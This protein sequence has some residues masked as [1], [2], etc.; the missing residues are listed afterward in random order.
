MI[1]SE[2]SEAILLD[3]PNS[4]YYPSYW[5]VRFNPSDMTYTTEEVDQVDFVAQENMYIVGNGFV[6]YPDLNWNPEEAILMDNHSVHGYGEHIFTKEGLAFSD[7]VSLKFIGQNTG[8]SPVDVG[9][10]E[11]YL[12]DAEPDTDGWQTIEPISWVP[13]KSGDGTADLKFNNQEGT[14]TV[15]YDHFAERALIWKE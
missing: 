4:N 9:F 1:N 3:A 13:T 12:E 7:A 14:Y 15:L 6:D 2:D 11:A 5:K 10:D 8:W